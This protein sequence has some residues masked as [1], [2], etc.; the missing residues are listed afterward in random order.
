[1]NHRAA[2]EHKGLKENFLW[3]FVAQNPIPQRGRAY[4]EVGWRVLATAFRDWDACTACHAVAG[5][6]RAHPSE[7]LR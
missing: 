2:K 5:T 3:S 7:L 6:R 4:G 1:L